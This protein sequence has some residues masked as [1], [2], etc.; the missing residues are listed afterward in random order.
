MERWARET[1]RLS[2]EDVIAEVPSP[3]TEGEARRDAEAFA[4]LYRRHV[5]AIHG[6]FHGRAPAPIAVELT[7][8]TFAQAA[9]S[10]RRFV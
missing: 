7:A 10:L 1:G 8:E 5:R 4:E 3:R 6:W 2:A 9:L